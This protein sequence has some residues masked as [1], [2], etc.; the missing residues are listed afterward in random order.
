MNGN[1]LFDII[2]HTSDHYILDAVYIRKS[3]PKVLS[4]K[5]I[6][7]IAAISALILCLGGCTIVYVLSLQDMKVREHNFYIPTAYDEE[8]NLIPSKP[9]HR[10]F[11]FRCRVRI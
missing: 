7:L 3:D 5:R 2:G 10:S 9:M 11:N 8:G 6:L 1:D 4:S